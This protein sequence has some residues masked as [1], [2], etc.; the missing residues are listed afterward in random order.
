MNHDSIAVLDFGGQ[1]VHLIATKIRALGVHAEIRD[2]DDPA[3]SFRH[4]KGIVLSGSPALSAFGEE[5]DWSRGVLDLGIPVLGFCFGHQEIAKHGGGSVEHREREY[6]AATLNIVTQSPLFEGLSEKELVWMSHGDTVTS[7]G[8]EFVELGY[9]TGGSGNGSAH[10]NSAIACEPLRQYGLQFHPEVDDSPCGVQIL[11]N[12][13]FQICGIDA[14]WA[15]GDQIEER[16]Q[17]IRDEVGDRTVLLLASGG[18]DSSVA[19]LLFHHALGGKQLHLLHID[20]GLMRKDESAHVK[21]NLTEVG[22]GDSL[23][24]V[25]ATDDFLAALDGLTEP[26]AKR[27]AIGDTF[28]AVFER[29]AAKLD[30]EHVVLGQGTIYPDT[31]ETGGTKRAHVIKTH[32]NR[33]PL[34]QEMIAQGRVCE[35]LKDLYKVEVRELGAALGLDPASIDRHPFPGPGLG[36][37]VAASTGRD[38]DFDE[39]ALRRQTDAALAGTGLTGL[40][41]PVRSVGV[42]ADVRSFEHPVLLHG[43]FPG[44]E[45][46]TRTVT[47]LT[48]SVDGINRCLFELSDRNP[49]RAELLPATVTRDRLA[50]LRELDAVV[51]GAL[52]RHGLMKTIWQCP[53]VIVP[54]RLDGRGSELVVLRPVL[55]ERAMTAR[56]GWIG[57]ACATEITDA[58]LRH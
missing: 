1:Y 58:L 16:A 45:E 52:E 9:S 51:M 36:I 2:P 46:L 26:E 35:P 37:R 21:E 41:L 14:D 42:K 47:S 3:D 10:R 7:L 5:E 50:L 33:V 17:A 8:G 57:E 20:N 13:A 22:L 55:S 54:V 38:D 40:P 29:E 53:T 56:P 6:G 31:I 32:H 18:V 4:Y 24:V 30:L 23:R 34:V 49:S 12:F 19:A 25:D 44:W 43:P 48:K 15:V 27:A 28:I 11:R 39:A